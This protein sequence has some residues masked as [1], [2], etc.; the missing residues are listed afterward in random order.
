MY[1]CAA[2]GLS[3]PAD[4]SYFHISYDGGRNPSID[5]ATFTANDE[6]F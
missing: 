4:V 5:S 6:G 2:V 1:D 3:G